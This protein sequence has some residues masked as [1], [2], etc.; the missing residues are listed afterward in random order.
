MRRPPS[1]SP[2]LQTTGNN[3]DQFCSRS[4]SHLI[5]PSE[6]QGQGSWLLNKQSFHRLAP[7]LMAEMHRLKRSKLCR[8]LSLI[9]AKSFMQAAATARLEAMMVADGPHT[10]IRR[11]KRLI[12]AFPFSSDMARCL[13]PRGGRGYLNELYVSHYIS[14][15]SRIY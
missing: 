15:P 8:P 9:G 11:E 7:L 1:A 3:S 13:V 4:D 6:L 2:A 5:S 10:H 14:V 12:S